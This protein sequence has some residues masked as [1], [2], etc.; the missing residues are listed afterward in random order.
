MST[1]VLGPPPA[2]LTAL[3]ERRRRAGADRL[4]EVWE[5]VHH[6]VPAPSGEHADLAQQLAVLIDGPARSAGLVPTMH[7][8]NLGESEHDFR[9]PDGG[10]H[11]QRP[12]GAWQATAALVI[13]IVSAG[14]ESREKLPFYAAH[15]VA[16]VVIVD[17][18]ERA[19]EWLALRDGGYQAVE[20]SGLVELGAAELAGRLDWP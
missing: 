17:P 19:V 11:R 1:L 9:V 7:E 10:L 20:R 18:A 16:E 6:V 2:E 12:R 14:D 5:G 13:E 8:F 3:L 15:D 4:D